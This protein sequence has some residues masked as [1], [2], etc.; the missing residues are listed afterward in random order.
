M[1][2]IVTINIP[3]IESLATAILAFAGNRQTV[4][5]VGVKPIAPEKQKKQ[6][7]EETKPAKQVDTQTEND[8]SNEPENTPGEA[9]GEAPYIPTVVELRAKAQE[10]GD[11]TEGKKAIKALLDK[12]NSKSISNVPEK[13]RAAF[14]SALEAL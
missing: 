3:A 10:K 1:N 11:T 2:I 8:L 6:T 13:D 12:F 14:L 7:K 9:T 4:Q 5:E